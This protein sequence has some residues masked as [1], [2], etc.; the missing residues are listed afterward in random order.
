LPRLSGPEDRSA[1]VAQRYLD[2]RDRLI[3][4]GLDLR[5]VHLDP[6]GAWDMTLNNGVEVRLGRRDIN[7]RTDLFLDIVAD[8]ITGRAADIDYVDMRYSNGFTIGW[9]NGSRTPIDDT[10]EGLDEMLAL[11]GDR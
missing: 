4:V 1:D 7:E 8:I 2:V 6:R 9:N 10:E 5:R 3:P 11:R